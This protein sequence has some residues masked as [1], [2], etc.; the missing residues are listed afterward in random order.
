MM[1]SQVGTAAASPPVPPP[2]TALT[3]TP[4]PSP[5]GLAIQWGAIGDV[6]LLMN[7]GISDTAVGGT[8]PQRIASCLEVLDLFLQQPCAVL[9]SFVLAEKSAA[10]RDGK[11]QQDLVQAVAHI[12]GE[13]SLWKLPLPQGGLCLSLFPH[14]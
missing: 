1:A 8:L 2:P 13:Y 7:V 9:S 5:T 4:A 6:G 11:G 3:Y 10:H 14:L 12:L